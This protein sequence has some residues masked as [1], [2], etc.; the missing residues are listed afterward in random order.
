[1]NI[2][3]EKQVAATRKKYPNG[4]RIR[5]EAM[6]QE[7]NPVPCG[8]CGT[9]TGVDDIGTI[10]MAWDNG[11]SLGIVPGIDKFTVIDRKEA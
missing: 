6:N 7:P 4:T 8:T 9:V 3:T 5:L 2:P 1:M 10:H 11:S